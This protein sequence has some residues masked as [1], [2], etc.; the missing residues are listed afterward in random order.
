MIILEFHNINLFASVKRSLGKQQGSNKAVPRRK[1]GAGLGAAL[2]AA[3]ERAHDQA[4]RRAD[5][6]ALKSVR[7]AIEATA[8]AAQEGA[9]WLV[10]LLRWAAGLLLLPLC[11][12][13][14]WTFLSQAADVTVRNA[15]WSTA[16]F[17][18]FATGVLLMAGWF[19]TGLGRPLFLYLY[20]LGHELTHIVFILCFGGRVKDWSVSLEG[21]HVTTNKSNIVIALAP[22]FVPFWSVVLVLCHLG[23]RWAVELP[24]YAEKV[25]F[26]GVGFTWTYHLLWTLWMIPRDQ[27]DLR[28]NGTFLSLVIIYFIN[29]LALAAMLCVASE[30]L[31]WRGFA[32]TFAI[33]ASEGVRWAGG[34]LDR[35]GDLLVWLR[36]AR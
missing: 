30:N 12:V 21:G 17:W 19:F 2:Q 36:L 32:V 5:R 9:P 6:R 28:E 7:A 1:R 27:P 4:N 35:F 20:V 18:Y 8:D 34:W 13:A 10:H 22:Y 11:W 29:L 26:F 23:L 16:A 3:N 31:S 14:T 15:F 24:P 25:M 33:H